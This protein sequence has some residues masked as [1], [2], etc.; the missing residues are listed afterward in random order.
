MQR[1][2]RVIVRKN[3]SLITWILLLDSLHKFIGTHTLAEL[4][5][6]MILSNL[7]ALDRKWRGIKLLSGVER[8]Q[9]MSDR[10]LGREDNMHVCHALFFDF[11]KWRFQSNF[12]VQMCNNIKNKMMEIFE[13]RTWNKWRFLIIFNHFWQFEDRNDYLKSIKCFFFP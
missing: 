1:L 12:Y 3:Y 13:E 9:H 2:Q 7:Y 8:K 4:N 5:K 10:V 6:V 11:K